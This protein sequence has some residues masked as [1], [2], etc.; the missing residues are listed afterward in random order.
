MLSGALKVFLDAKT[1]AHLGRNFVVQEATVLRFSV[2]VGFLTT[3]TL[4]PDTLT[5]PRLDLVINRKKA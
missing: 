1:R 5:T 3:Q 4:K 2:P